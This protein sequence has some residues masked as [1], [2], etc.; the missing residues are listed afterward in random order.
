MNKKEQFRN[1]LSKFE[2]ENP[3]LVESIV[4]AYSIIFENEESESINSSNTK[5]G[6][7]V[8]YFNPNQDSEFDQ[9][10][11]LTEEH[12]EVGEIYTVDYLVQ[13]GNSTEI[14]LKEFPEKGFNS[15]FFK[16]YDVNNLTIDRILIDNPH[17]EKEFIKIGEWKEEKGK[18]EIEHGFTEYCE[19][20]V[21]S[22]GNE[23]IYL[24]NKD[25]TIYLGA[26]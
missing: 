1:F 7:K 16:K 18:W 19:V 4:K 5:K 25:G 11:E 9:Q 13:Q 20:I 10:K 3:S 26:N 24:K 6:D 8:V 15:S 2:E 23:A 12:L 21:N 14:F 22:K 17:A